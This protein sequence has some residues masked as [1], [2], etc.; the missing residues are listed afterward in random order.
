MGPLHH[1]FHGVE[2]EL[3][4]IH[5]GGNFRGGRSESP[6]KKLSASQRQEKTAQS[7][8]R[9][10]VVD[11]RKTEAQIQASSGPR[12]VTKK[13]PFGPY[14]NHASPRTQK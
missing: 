10:T 7:P 6:S 13:G 8:A 14:L 3:R 2:N 9:P 1:D 12:K 5:K 4:N 11:P